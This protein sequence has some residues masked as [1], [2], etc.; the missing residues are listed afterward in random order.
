MRRCRK[1]RKGKLRR[2]AELRSSV[3]ATRGKQRSV[4]HVQNG[5]FDETGSVSSATSV[6]HVRKS[7]LNHP[8][9]SAA[10]TGCSLGDCVFFCVLVICEC[11]CVISGA[12]VH[13]FFVSQYR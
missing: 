2:D 9:I 12:N 6:T 10:V 13:R 5:V 11:T 3:W 1:K 8:R 7:P 4:I